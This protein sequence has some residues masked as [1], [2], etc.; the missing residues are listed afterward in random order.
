MPWY[1]QPISFKKFL[2]MNQ[3]QPT[4]RPALL[5]LLRPKPC[6]VFV[7]KILSNV[8][9][10]PDEIAKAMSISE[11]DLVSFIDGNVEVTIEFSRK[12]ELAIKVN[13]GFWL[14]LQKYHDE[15]LRKPH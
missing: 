2:T 7:K 6:D 4:I 3:S 13:A 1:R 5:L 12:L 15:Y 10:K 14:N 11:T 8:E 9:L